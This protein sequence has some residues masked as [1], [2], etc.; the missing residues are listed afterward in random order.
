MDWFPTVFFTF[1]F[2]VL[3]VGMYF[4]IKWHYDQIQKAEKGAAIRAGGIMAGAFLLLLFA[5]G[6]LAFAV[7]KVLGLNLG[8]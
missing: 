3:G 7:S 4:A 6:L 1:K 8:F 2:L 5:V